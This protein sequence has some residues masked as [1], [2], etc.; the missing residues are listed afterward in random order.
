MDWQFVVIIAITQFLVSLATS[1][2]IERIRENGR[3]DALSDKEDKDFTKREKRDLGMLILEYINRLGENLTPEDW[4]KKG[5]AQSRLSVY[6]PKLSDMWSEY[7]ARVFY[8]GLQV[9]EGTWKTD[10]KLY[11]EN[12]DRINELRKDLDKEG[13]K[14]IG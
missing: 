13:N 7:D 14:L 12:V 2:I 10:V 9:K 6:N 8:Q 3:L 4:T 11:Q 1:Y 5:V